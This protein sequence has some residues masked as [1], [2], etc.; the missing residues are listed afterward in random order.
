MKSLKIIPLGGLGEI[1]MN[2]MAIETDTTL[3]L[4]DC[5]VLFSELVDFGVEYVIPDF[6]YVLERREK[7]KAVVLTHGHEDHIGAIPYLFQE[8]VR[9]PLFSSLFTSLML[10]EK[11]SEFGYLSETQINVFKS[12]EVFKV[13]D[14]EFCPVS[15]NHSIVDAMALE[16]RTPLGTLV[17]TGDFKID[18]TPPYGKTMDSE[19]FR[20]LGEKGVLL[21]MSDSTNVERE[22][23]SQSEKVVSESFDRIFAVAEGMTVVALFSSNIARVAQIFELAKRHNK[24]VALSGRSMEQNVRLALESGHIKDIQSVFISLDEVEKFERDQIILLTT[25]TQGE[26]RSSLKRIARGE[27]SL[28]SVQPKDQILMSSRFIPGNERAV[29]QMINQLFEQGAQVLYEATHQIHVSGHATKPEL[30]QMLKWTKPRFFLPIHGEYR[31]LVLHGAVAEEAG[32]PVEQILVCKNGSILELSQQKFEKVGETTDE[33]KRFLDSTIG[34]RIS[35][36]IL[37]DR[38]RLAEGGVVFVIACIDPD[39]KAIVAGPQI[40]FKGVADSELE[41]RM[42]EAALKAAQAVFKS[43]QAKAVRGDYSVDLAE[44]IRVNVRRS[45]QVFVGKK[46]TTVPYLLEI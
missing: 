46:V 9:P 38:R 3:V 37:R 39:R 24:K 4:I 11:M 45:L 6:S 19:Y 27:H 31:H 42:Y 21:L 22:E 16:I 40:L 35:K 34:N 30:L 41:K 10:R 20:K 13:G 18:P 36:D 25:G 14:I 28:V 5:G 1:G 33:P 32:L 12:H 43:Y 17:H 7:L 26:P 29:G 44:E 8:G 15:V 23:L 2:C